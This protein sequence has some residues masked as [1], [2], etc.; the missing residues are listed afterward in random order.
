MHPERIGPYR[1]SRKIGAG[2]MGNVY[3]GTHEDTG[4]EVAVKVLPVS[5]AR[6]E[7]FVNRFSR[8]VDALRKVT[9]PN[10]VQIYEDGQTDDGSYYFSMEYVD[11]ETLTSVVSR[12]KRIPWQEVMEISQQ[13]CT[14]LKA[15]HDAG[16][17]HRDLKPSNL[18]IARD[19]TVKLA[20]FGVAHVLPGLG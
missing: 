17:V 9:S 10:I 4:Q 3:H 20:D 12:R 13:I 2:G 5:M 18:M 14:A 7:G 6:E 15:A 16:I 1:I 8:E 19:G 11:G